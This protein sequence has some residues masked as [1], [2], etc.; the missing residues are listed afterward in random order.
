[1][2]HRRTVQQGPP[3]DGI[4]QVKTIR[5]NTQGEGLLGCDQCGKT[6][7]VHLAEMQHLGK[8]LKNQM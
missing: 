5:L 1:M 7:V 4:M 2:D 3:G 8:R 6:K